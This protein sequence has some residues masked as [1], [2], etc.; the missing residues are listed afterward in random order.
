VKQKTRGLYRRESRVSQAFAYCL[1]LLVGADGEK[2]IPSKDATF[3]HSWGFCGAVRLA[4]HRDP[5]W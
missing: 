5:N 2:P 3:W 1:I 4:L